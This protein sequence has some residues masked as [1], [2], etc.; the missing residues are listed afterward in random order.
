MWGCEECRISYYSTWH[1]GSLSEAVNHVDLT[2]L[3]HVP[4]NYLASCCLYK[5][6]KWGMLCTSFVSVLTIFLFHTKM[7]STFTISSFDNFESWS[8]FTVS[9]CELWHYFFRTAN[10]PIVHW[11]FCIVSVLLPGC[12]VLTSQSRS[13][14]AVVPG[15]TRSVTPDLWTWRQY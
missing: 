3:F 11:V 12:E 15:S 1:V 13:H 5:L 4:G 7:I 8:L 14:C 2:S 6:L 9:H 10:F